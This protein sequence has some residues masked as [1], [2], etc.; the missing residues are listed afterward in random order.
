MVHGSPCIN[1]PGQPENL[2][3]DIVDGFA[4]CVYGY[5]HLSV[6]TVITSR[7]VPTHSV[8]E[9]RHYAPSLFAKQGVELTTFRNMPGGKLQAYACPMAFFFVLFF[10]FLQIVVS[11]FASST[12]P[13]KCL[14]WTPGPCPNQHDDDGRSMFPSRFL[15]SW[16]FSYR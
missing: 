14:V 12:P 6:R 13:I 9:R 15:T 11:E 2:K 10:R 1:P 7:V 5:I 8:W 3:P 16:E 4:F